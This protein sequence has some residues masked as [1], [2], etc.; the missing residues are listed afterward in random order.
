MFAFVVLFQV[1]PEAFA[2]LKPDMRLLAAVE[3]RGVVVTCKAEEAGGGSPAARGGAGTYS[4]GG[5]VFVAT[6]ATV[7]TAIGSFGGTLSQSL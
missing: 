4:N 3:T 2:T 6:T 1:T 7:L 5:N